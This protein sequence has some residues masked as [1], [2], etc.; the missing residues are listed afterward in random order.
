MAQPCAISWIVERQRE[1]ATL[2]E[3]AVPM[4]DVSREWIRRVEDQALHW[5]SQHA[6]ATVLRE[7]AHHMAGVDDTRD[8]ARIGDDGEG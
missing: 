1:P 2:E 5:L 3:V 7:L 6:D 4:G 8:A